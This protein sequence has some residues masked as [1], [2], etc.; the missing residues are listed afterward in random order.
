MYYIITEFLNIFNLRIILKTFP[1]IL[2]KCGYYRI[3]E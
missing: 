1:V 3:N 2:E